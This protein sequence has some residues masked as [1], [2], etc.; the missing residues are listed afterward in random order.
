LNWVDYLLILIVGLSVLSGLRA[1]FARVGIGF[2]AAIIGIFGGFWCYGIVAD[3]FVDYVSSKAIANLIGF[4]V[5][6]VGV[7]L[8][9]ALIGRLVAMLFKWIG[10]SWFDRLLGG[11]FGFVRGLVVAAA[12]TTVLMAFA[13]SPPPRSITESRTLPYVV[14]AAGILAAATPREIKD[15]F[16]DSLEKVKR[17]WEEHLKDKPSALPRQN[18]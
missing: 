14:D 3:H 13:P 4:F 6:F 1:G 9:G 10:L 7:V 12:L 16:H 8:V 2:A 17:I 15:A 11:A 5:I 18:V